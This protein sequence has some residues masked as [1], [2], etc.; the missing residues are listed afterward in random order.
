MSPGK[1]HLFP[2]LNQTVEATNLKSNKTGNVILLM[3]LLLLWKIKKVLNIYSECVFVALGIHHAMSM[4][5]TVICG[6]FGSTKFF[7]VSHTWHDKK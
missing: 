3:Q 2:A 4:H 6:L 7:T 1:Y 5:H